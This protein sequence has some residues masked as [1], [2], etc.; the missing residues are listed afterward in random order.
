MRHHDPPHKRLRQA[1][2]DRD[3]RMGDSSAAVTLPV[4]MWAHILDGL[5]V[6]CRHILDPVCRPYAAS[7]CRMWAAIV[8]SPSVHSANVL[9]WVGPG[10]ARHRPHMAPPWAHGR[11]VCASSVVNALDAHA[12][13][14]RDIDVIV[15]RTMTLP[16][17]GYDH[18]VLCLL[19]TGRA[20][21]VDRALS[22]PM[23][24]T[25]CEAMAKRIMRSHESCAGSEWWID[26]PVWR[27]AYKPPHEPGSRSDELVGA[28]MAVA[29]RRGHADLCA[30]LLN[31][32]KSI[33]TCRDR[34]WKDATALALPDVAVMLFK[35]AVPNTPV[36]SSEPGWMGRFGDIGTAVG[37]EAVC[38]AARSMAQSD[39]DNDAIMGDIWLDAIERYIKCVFNLQNSAESDRPGLLAYY[40][41]HKI[42]Y[43]PAEIMRHAARSGTADTCARLWNAHA[44]ALVAARVTPE[45]IADETTRHATTC[46]RLRDKL[47]WLRDVFGFVPDASWAHALAD[48][49]A[50]GSITTRSLTVAAVWPR[51]AS[52][53]IADALVRLCAREH[54][55]GGGLGTRRRPVRSGFNA[56]GRLVG[57]D[58]ARHRR[59]QGLFCLL[60]VFPVAC[61]VVVV[62]GRP[63]WQGDRVAQRE[64]GRRL[65]RVGGWRVGAT[66]R[67][68]L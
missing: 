67:A 68:R 5:D 23:W 20:T 51:C 63:L 21:L 24:E 14:D 40:D 11:L 26:E 55:R 66:R 18:V 36:G 19:A 2:H 30:R 56:A 3:D 25:A 12:G 61:R 9:S 53:L 41:A 4:E 62:A 1:P 47:V 35:T 16:G 52:P 60:L 8:R 15:K 22:G 28:A 31:R 6:H 57:R 39:N 29:A 33:T 59:L 37:I 32:Y 38:Q 17:V 13:C 48:S 10:A 50:R 34:C 27:I 58:A 46:A 45:S 65:G 7:V 54:N 44:A 49:D 43:D 42:P 64:R